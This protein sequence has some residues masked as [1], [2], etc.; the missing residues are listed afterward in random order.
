MHV[1]PLDLYWFVNAQDARRYAEIIGQKLITGTYS[2]IEIVVGL[3][4]G[5]LV[6]LTSIC[7]RP[8]NHREKSIGK[9]T[10]EQPPLSL[11]LYLFGHRIDI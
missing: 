8:R 10:L 7:M 3:Y 1:I 4:H 2:Q 5:T 11:A 9:L 6:Y